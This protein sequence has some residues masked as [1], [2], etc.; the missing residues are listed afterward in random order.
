MR[1]KLAAAGQ[2][3]KGGKM[4]NGN[5]DNIRSK[6]IFS[7]RFQNGVEII[8][9]ETINPTDVNDEQESVSDRRGPRLVI[10]DAVSKSKLFIAKSRSQL[11]EVDSFLKSITHR[12]LNAK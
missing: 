10:N 8:E 11:G 3:W 9:H 6:E 1:R 4:T 7:R 12:P 5:S 2:H